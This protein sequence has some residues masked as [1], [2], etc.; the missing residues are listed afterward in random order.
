MQPEPRPAVVAKRLSREEIR[1]RQGALKRAMLR[2]LH[3]DREPADPI[4]TKLF[5]DLKLAG[6]AI[7]HSP[8]REEARVYEREVFEFLIRWLGAL[9]RPDLRPNAAEP[10]RGCHRSS[11]HQPNGQAANGETMTPVRIDD[12]L[13]DS[14]MQRLIQMLLSRGVDA[15]I[16]DLATRMVAYMVW[17]DTTHGSKPRYEFFQGVA[18]QLVEN[19]R[20]ALFW[21]EW[22]QHNPAGP[23]SG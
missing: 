3:A 14:E 2:R 12:E 17:L 9:E 15:T 4:T 20:D 6:W 22:R 18:D 23:L 8:D 21:K 10:W 11:R 13:F 19:G 7:R 5:A 1:H 16:S